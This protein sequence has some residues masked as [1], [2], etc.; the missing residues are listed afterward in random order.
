M[1]KTTS[2]RMLY[3]VSAV[4]LSLAVSVALSLTLSSL[5]AEPQDSILYVSSNGDC[6]DFNPLLYCNP[7]SGGRCI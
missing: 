5:T 1:C 4:A 2:H 6:R 7:G 3:L